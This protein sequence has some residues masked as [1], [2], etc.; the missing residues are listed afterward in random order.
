[1]N[2][3]QG[4]LTP[5]LIQEEIECDPYK[6]T[7]GIFHRTRTKKCHNSYGNT[8]DPKYSKQP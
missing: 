6:I 4:I 2:K 5:K 7:N 1:M 3:F 8:K